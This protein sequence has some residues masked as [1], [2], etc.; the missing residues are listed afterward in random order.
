MPSALQ[1]QTTGTVDH[2]A[3]FLIT[4]LLFLDLISMV[5]RLGT[6]VGP[7]LPK[8]TE[9][10]GNRAPIRA[11]SLPSHRRA[12][13]SSSKGALPQL[14]T[15]FG[16]WGNFSARSKGYALPLEETFVRPLG[17]ALP[18]WTSFLQ[19]IKRLFY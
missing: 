17:F 4:C 9:R 3:P 12:V 13:R 18:L 10:P 19:G 8:Q 11:Q 15:P 1:G 14:S 6:L 16:G 2:I 5:A 7:P